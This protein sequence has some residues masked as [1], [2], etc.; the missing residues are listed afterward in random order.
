MCAATRQRADETGR[1]PRPQVARKKEASRRVKALR[2]QISAT[3]N[4]AADLE[5]QQQHLMRQQATLKDRIRKLESQV[6]TGGSGLRVEAGQWGRRP[7]RRRARGRG[8]GGGELGPGR[9]HRAA[10]QGGGRGDLASICA[11]D[12][13]PWLRQAVLRHS[14]APGGGPAL[15][16]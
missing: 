14:R 11:L 12:P 10:V 16:A 8:G 13:S 9:A 5:A 4:D 3:S 1:A 7:L 6:G 2:E 15:G